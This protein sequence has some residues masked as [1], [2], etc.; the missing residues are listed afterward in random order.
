MANVDDIPPPPAPSAYS[1]WSFQVVS[2]GGSVGG[3]PRLEIDVPPTEVTPGWLAGSVTARFRS[4]T[5]S[6]PTPA[7]LSMIHA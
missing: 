3:D 1:S 6:M 5:M 2:V 7:E 4:W